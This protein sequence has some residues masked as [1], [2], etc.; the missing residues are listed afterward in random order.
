[1]KRFAVLLSLSVQ[2]TLLAGCA[3]IRP[4]ALPAA[5]LADADF[6]PPSEPVG[7]DHLSTLSP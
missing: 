7:T 1:M 2:L 6:A 3:S 4:P 5:P